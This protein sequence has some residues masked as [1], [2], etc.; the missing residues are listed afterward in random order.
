MLFVFRIGTASCNC[1]DRQ[2]NYCRHKETRDVNK[3]SKTV[4]S[5]VNRGKPVLQTQELKTSRN[6][7][8]LLMMT[9]NKDAD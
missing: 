4:Q 8:G 9:L 6:P 3:T 1:G 5:R 7:R 2:G